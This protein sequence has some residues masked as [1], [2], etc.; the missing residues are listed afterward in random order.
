MKNG[1]L[2]RKAGVAAIA[3]LSAAGAGTAGAAAMRQSQEGAKNGAAGVLAVDGRDEHQGVYSVGVWIERTFA[4]REVA[5]QRW[6]C[7]ISQRIALSARLK[8]RQVTIGK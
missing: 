2:V 7:F 5:T 3:M 4:K 1:M 6:K 8:T